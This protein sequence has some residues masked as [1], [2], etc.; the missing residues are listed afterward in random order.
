MKEIIFYLFAIITVVPA[1]IVV[2]TKNIIYAA[3]ALMF[4]LFGV[5]G[6]YVFL[7]ADF[8]AAVQVLIYVGGILVLILFGVMLTRGILDLKLRA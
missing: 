3:F 5:A 8:L 4:T 2:T 6:L 7:S 1:V